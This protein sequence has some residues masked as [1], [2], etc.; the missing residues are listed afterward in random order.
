MGLLLLQLSTQ[1]ENFISSIMP[2]VLEFKMFILLHYF[3]NIAPAAIKQRVWKSHILLWLLNG[4]SNFWGY[5]RRFGSPLLS[6]L[7][8][9]SSPNNMQSDI[10]YPKPRPKSFL[11]F[12][13]QY[14]VHHFKSCDKKIIPTRIRCVLKRIC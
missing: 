1:R 2:H 13:V 5:L 14:Y 8:M 12:Y 4:K 11:I 6:T 10:Y 3:I 7:L 9:P